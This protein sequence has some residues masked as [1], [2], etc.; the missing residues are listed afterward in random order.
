[1]L[2]VPQEYS[3]FLSFVQ[4]E[5]HDDFQPVDVLIVYPVFEVSQ[6]PKKIEQ[7]EQQHPTES[8]QTT[9][10]NHNIYIDL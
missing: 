7:G 10:S 2:Q 1:M 9:A 3:A 6:N 8:E 4:I 5:A